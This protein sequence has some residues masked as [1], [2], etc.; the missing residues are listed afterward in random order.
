MNKYKK[1]RINKTS[2]IDEH[3]LVMQNHIGRKLDR[4]EI[5]HHKNGIKNDNRIENLELKELSNHTREHQIKGDIHKFT[6]CDTQKSSEV[7]IKD[8]I[9]RRFRHGKYMC[10]TCKSFRC[11]N[12]FYKTISR[13]FGLDNKCKHCRKLQNMKRK[14][15]K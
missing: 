12:E 2:T 14:L 8:A 7:R 6:K 3:R 10:I 1:I 13:I 9:N 4:M 11:R 15:K 5:V